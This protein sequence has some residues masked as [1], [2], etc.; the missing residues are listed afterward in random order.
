[1]I[2][3][4]YERYFQTCTCNTR[5]L[6]FLSRFIVRVFSLIRNNERQKATSTEKKEKRKGK[7]DRW[8]G[9]GRGGKGRKKEKQNET[10]V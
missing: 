5:Y 10:K 2:Q 6:E 1:M 3:K 8:G 4:N 7:K 9:E